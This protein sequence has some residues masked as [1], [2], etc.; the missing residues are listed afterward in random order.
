M[1]EGNIRALE[2]KRSAER[3]E[4]V[5]LLETVLESAKDE[6]IQSVAVVT[7]NADGSVGTGY[8]PGDMFYQLLGGLTELQCQMFVDARQDSGEL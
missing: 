1:S 2:T 6:S 5:R 7:V 4:A 3:K 8:V